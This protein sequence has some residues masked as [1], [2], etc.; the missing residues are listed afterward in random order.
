[1]TSSTS[2]KVPGGRGARARRRR[3]AA[4]ADTPPAPDSLWF[5]DAIIYECHVRAFSDGNADGI[6]DF[7]GLREKLEYLEELGV[8]AIWLLPFYASPLRDDGY[9][10]AD[11]Y[12]V[13]PD[14]GNTR[15]FQAFL[16]E[17]HRRGLRVITE[18]VLNHTSEQHAW[19]QRARNAPAGSAHRNFYVWS[20]TATEY[21]A[22]RIIFTDFERSNWTW[23]PVAQAHY[24]HRF[25]SHQP[26]LNFES[27]DV[28]RAMFEVVDYWLGLGVDGLRLDAVPYLFEREGTSCE[29]LPETHA[30]LKELR[31]HVDGKFPGRMLLAEA[32]QWPDDAAAYFGNGDE[33]HMAFHFP[34]MPRLFMAVRTEDRY[35]ITEILEQTPAIAENA[36]WALFLRNHDELTLEMVT[37]EERDFMNRVYAHDEHARI[38]LGIRRRLAPLLGHNRRLIELMNALLFSLKGTPVIYYGDEIG[39]G[40]NIYLGDRNGVRTPMQWSGDRNAGF[41]RANPQQLF[42]P[43]IID[44]EYH[45]ESVNVESQQRNPSLLLAWMKRLIALRRR[46]RAFG[47][48]SIEFLDTDN[49]RVLAFLRRYDGECMLVVANLSRFVQAVHIS[50]PGLAG[51]VPLELFGRTQFP[52]ITDRPYFLSL[53]PHT[54]FW[55]TLEKPA[56]ASRP[57]ELTRLALLPDVSLEK[58][59]TESRHRTALEAVLGNY[60][61]A[62]RWFGGKARAV[63]R[64]SMV[65]S[66]PVPIAG[67]RD[68]CAY[69]V[70]KIEYFEGEAD[71]YALPLA[72]VVGADA[73][74][75]TKES[76]WASVAWLG[77]PD[78]PGAR[79]LVDA[80]ALPD[81]HAALLG[82]IGTKRELPGTGGALRVARTRLLGRDSGLTEEPSALQH[83]EQSNSSLMVGSRYVFKLIRRIEMGVSPE[84]EMQ[85]FLERSGRFDHTPRLAAV[86]D[87]ARAD[88]ATATEGILQTF[89]ANECDAW[90]YTLGELDHFYQGIAEEQP[91]LPER[92]AETGI[93]E[94]VDRAAPAAMEERGGAYLEL[95]SLLGQRVAELHVAL[96]SDATDKQFARERYTPFYQKA[97]AQGARSQALRALRLLRQQQRSLP[98]RSAELAAEV[99]AKE[100][101]IVARLM[102]VGERPIA[103]V[104]IRC[105]NDLHLGQVLFTGK[106]FYV[107][108]F[109]GEPAKPLGERKLK[110]SPLW[111]V[112]GML[113]SFHYATVFALHGPGIET[114]ADMGEA[115]AGLERWGRLWSATAGAAF[116]SR[117]LSVIAPAEIVPGRA[118]DVRLLLDNFLL[119]KAFAELRYELNNRPQWA[120]IPL[121]GIVE[122][123]RTP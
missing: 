107:I 91:E 78:G 75:A 18:L 63:R 98:E 88:G 80:V 69:T 76:P 28:R 12:R 101:E 14:Y 62:R 15:D 119:E 110:R 68:A 13:H 82:F 8:T 44:P 123:L 89:I 56:D 40:D 116:L 81:F 61:P 49:R 113:R 109:E 66:I 72:V 17:A 19:F 16:A 86:M 45:Y 83:G 70:V 77:A 43:T 25:Y 87:Y 7:K 99:L 4:A 59:T 85:Q 118:A 122:C 104:R 32:N 5:K 60:V 29:N 20:D 93:W 65:D 55:F 54:F 50:L 100:S 21:S 115:T 114:P 95:A 108:D 39:M 10:I 73:H 103:G 111:D 67:G 2:P 47:R 42:L 120:A 34:L 48:G 41:S 74:T 9:D 30:F 58:L 6:G 64:V 51:N 37:D 11:Y 27:P 117:Y 84:V 22:A 33:C 57:D 38:N 92:L 96:A 102:Q 71:E 1:M 24:W 35:P 23:D 52:E 79:L 3:S 112:A 121:A 90:A 106:D 36:Q 31:T 26:D 97:L 46:H 94:L 53:G 105:H